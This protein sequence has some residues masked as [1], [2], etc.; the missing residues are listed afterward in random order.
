MRQN[1][2]R[3]ALAETQKKRQLAENH[4][5]PWIIR[6][7]KGDFWSGTDIQRRDRLEGAKIKGEDLTGGL[8]IPPDQLMPFFLAARSAS[9]A[10]KDIPVPDVECGPGF[11]CDGSDLAGWP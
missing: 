4:L 9:G 3:E 6:H 11:L 1:N 5:R 10:G 7:N 8:D 2:F